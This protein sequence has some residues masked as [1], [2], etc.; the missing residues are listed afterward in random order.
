MGGFFDF[1]SSGDND[2]V[3]EYSFFG[4]PYRSL[5]WRKGSGGEGFVF[6]PFAFDFMKSR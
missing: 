3:S 4:D 6:A 5:F 2:G 1:I